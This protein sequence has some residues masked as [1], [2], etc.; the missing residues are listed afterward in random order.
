[1]GEAFFMGI[2]AG[3]LILYLGSWELFKGS[4][5]FIG[6][7]TLEFIYKH[8]IQIVRHLSDQEE[9]YLL[10]GILGALGMAFFL[11]WA[12]PLLIRKFFISFFRP[13]VIGT[14]V[15]IILGFGYMVFNYSPT[16][17]IHGDPYILVNNIP[18]LK[19][20]HYRLYQKEKTTPLVK[21]SE[22]LLDFYFRKSLLKTA[23]TLQTSELEPRREMSYY[24]QKVDRSGIRK[25]NVIVLLVESLRADRLEYYGIHKNILPNIDQLARKGL[26]FT[27][28]YAQSSHSDY[29]DLCTLSSL[30]PLRSDTHHYY[31]DKIPYPRVLLYDILKPLGYQTAI[32]SS[33]DEYWGHMYHFLNTGNLDIFFHAQSFDRELLTYEEDS[34]AFKYFKRQKTK[35]GKVEDRYTVDAAI[36]WI[37]KIRGNPFF[38]Y[39]NLQR[40]HFPYKVPPGFRGPFQAPPIDFHVRFGDYPKEKVPVLMNAY[41]N[42]LNYVDTQVGRL[43]EGLQKAGVLDETILVITGDN[44]QAFYEHDVACHAS[45]LYEEIVHVPVVLFG[46]GIQPGIDRRYVEHVDIPPSILALLNLP[47]HPIFQ[48]KNL[49]SG[50]DL[51]GRS[52]FLTA[53][54]GPFHQDAII[55]NGKKLI[56]DHTFRTRY[57]YDLEEDPGETRNL[58]PVKKDLEADL[59]RRLLNYRKKQTDY[60]RDPRFYRH[61]FPPKF[62]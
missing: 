36:Q 2:W 10:V 30:Y 17:H 38:I 22:D 3:L 15:F 33:Q 25:F 24:L 57:L 12:L 61:F 32:F 49:L 55:R 29:A 45:K 59:M 27:R 52:I 31:P 5:H 19:T 11:R 48:G 58:I 54:V 42:S 18:F 34:V 16:R 39:M 44:G 20:E 1:V 13:L 23:P 56:L 9:D 46:P 8:K 21:L 41:N 47:P 4:G 43:I 40:S 35:A 37:R 51:S 7:E 26:S 28:A 53:Q 62:E 14:G 50:D 6:W 60:Y